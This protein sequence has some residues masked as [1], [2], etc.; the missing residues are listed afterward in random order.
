MYSRPR[1]QVKCQGQTWSTLTLAITFELS[2]IETSNLVFD[3]PYWVISAHDLHLDLVTL[4]RSRSIVLKIGLPV[5]FEL[6]KIEASNLVFDLPYRISF[7]TWPSPW[8]CDL[9]K[10]QGQ[11]CDCEK[12]S[13]LCKN[14]EWMLGSWWY[15]HT[16]FIIMKILSWHKVKVR[17]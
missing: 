1:S 6:L 8:P 10:G 13:I 15:L 17:G 11:T 5:T 14:H 7:S 3:L 4:K 9:G 2:K 16:G 12:Y